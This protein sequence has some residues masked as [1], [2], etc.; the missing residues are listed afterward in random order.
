MSILELKLEDITVDF[1]FGLPPILG[2]FD[3]IW[4]IVDRLTILLVRSNYNTEKFAK[5]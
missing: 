4:V 3:S 2:K 1:I 5:L